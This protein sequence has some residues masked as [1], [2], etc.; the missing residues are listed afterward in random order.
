MVAQPVKNSSGITAIFDNTVIFRSI[1][2]NSNVTGCEPN[3]SVRLQNANQF[4]RKWTQRPQILQ[5]YECCLSVSFSLRSKTARNVNRSD[6]TY[7]ES[8]HQIPTGGEDDS[9]HAR[10]GPPMETRW[11]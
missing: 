8:A 9:R 5:T 4:R 3:S 11:W 10:F 2:N 1:S 6:G 7:P